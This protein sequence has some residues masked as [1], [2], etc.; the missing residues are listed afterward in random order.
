MTSTEMENIR[1]SIKR[2][3]PVSDASIAQLCAHFK[4]HHFPARHLIIRGGIIDRNVYFIEKGLTRS[5]C[6]VNGN[7]HTTWFSKEGDI[8]F[9]LLCL[10]HNRAGFEYVETVEPT[11]A[12]SIPI[13]CLNHL[14]QKS[15]ASGVPALAAVH[16]H[17]QSHHDCQRKVSGAAADFSGYL[18]EGQPGIHRFLSGHI[19][20][21]LKPDQG[22]EIACLFCHKS[23]NKNYFTSTFAAKKYEN[24]VN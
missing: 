14:Y 22:R 2:H 9:G 8:T 17:R 15:G 13:H 16:P 4:V 12:Y 11:L 24:T 5:Y 1:K 23:K 18:P 3:Y 21:Y 20:L 7:E 19:P 10:Y 6:L